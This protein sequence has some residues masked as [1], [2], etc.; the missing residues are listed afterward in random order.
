MKKRWKFTATLMLLASLLL[1]V[2][3]AHAG[4]P[5]GDG[6]FL[7]YNDPALTTEEEPAAAYSSDRQEYLVVWERNAIWGQRVATSGE[8]LGAPFEIS[9]GGGSPD[10]TYNDT[11]NEYFV[12]W[13]TGA[14]VQGRRLSKFGALLGSVVDVAIGYLPPPG[15]DGWYYDQPAVDYASTQNRYLVVYRYRRDSDGGSS[16]RARSYNSDGTPEAGGF[17]VGPYSALTVPEQPALA[18]NRSRNEFLVAWQR[19]SVSELDVYAVRVKMK[20]GAAVSGSVFVV[21]SASGDEYAPAVAAIP[22]VPEE[23]QYLVAWERHLGS[24]TNI[25]AKSVSGDAFP[26]PTRRY[27]ANTGWGE[28]SPAAAGSES[29]DHFLVTWT[30]VPS[31]TPP[32]MFEIQGRTLALDGSLLSDTTLIG[33][34]QVF[35]SA[36]VAGPVGDF[37]VAFDDNETFGTYSRGIY[38][39]LWGNRLYLPLLIRQ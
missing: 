15:T 1:I 14:D 12:V 7:I 31:P 29:N 18:Y 5:L 20:D 8:L 21:A 23:G 3:T 2:S 17:E 22:T 39:R 27:L 16:I 30:W 6:K 4:A 25:E 37:L 24:D 19:T 35:D 38:G 10:V 34:R 9:A 36:V 28:N 26:S 13:Q 32:G 11:D 33:G